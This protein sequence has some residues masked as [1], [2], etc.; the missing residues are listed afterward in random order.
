MKLAVAYTRVSSAEQLREGFSVPVQKSI[1]DA[2]AEKLGIT[3]EAHFS[4]DETG[5][6]KTARAE[7]IRMV[8]YLRSHPK[9]RTVLVEKV[10][11]LYRNHRDYVTL[12][13]IGVEI[14]FIKLGLIVGVGSRSNDLLQHDIQLALARHYLA[15][16]SEEV[17]K[18]MI[19][20]CEEG[21]YPSWAPLG[22]ANVKDA[23]EK[24]RSGGLALDPAKAPLVR[25]LFEAAATGRYSLGDLVRLADR[26]ALRGRYGSHIGKSQMVKILNCR[27]YTGWFDWS[28]KRYRGTY[29]P[30]ITPEMYDLTHAA[31]ARATRS[32]VLAHSFAYSG[33]ARCSACGGVLTGD[34][35]KGRY[36]YYFCR[37]KRWFP[38][39]HFDR[40][41]AEVLGSLVIDD[42]VSAFVLGELSRWY[43]AA[44]GDESKR[45]AWVRKRLAELQHFAD[46]AYEEKLLGAIDETTWRGRDAR[47]SAE[48][49]RLREEM[50]ALKPAIEKAEF[51]RR[52]GVP[53]ELAKTA[54]AQYLAQD[55]AQKGRLLKTCCSNFLV[56]DGSISICLRSP[57]DVIAK[58]GGSSPWLTKVDDIRTYALAILSQA[59]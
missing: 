50:A 39:A 14:H 1:A 16:L 21:G 51:L 34:L 19:R 5:G 38:E 35:K 17:K 45:A 53:F 54:A 37:C 30:L 24:K 7:F 6:Q 10:D 27:T 13:E 2:Y 56:T 29:E 33:I 23:A 41:M 26:L 31:L 40:A 55:S 8:A 32:K 48:A 46:A 9:V 57:F 22:Y 42:A 59:A 36:V 18:G 43:D 58:M 44:A 28:G 15:N 3:I 11:R 25:Q 4:A 47:W 20:K 12:D 49:V 52:A